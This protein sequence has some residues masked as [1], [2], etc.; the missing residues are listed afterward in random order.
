MIGI[1]IRVSSTKQDTA[2]QEADLKAYANGKESSWY[3]DKA[4]G[5]NMDRPGFQRLLADVRT[6]KIKTIVVW[7]LDRLGRTASGLTALFD[8]LQSLGVNLVSLRD[9]IDLGTSSGRLMA[10]I[11]ASIAAYE[12]EV[13]GERIAAGLAAKRER[14]AKGEDTWNA[15]RPKGTPNKATPEVCQAVREQVAKGIDKATVAKMFSL[16]R[17]TVYAILRAA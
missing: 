16:S 6:R 12:T 2:S 1:Y 15:G 11:I 7:R 8:E 3:Q 17:P 5:K 4:T 10:N 13:R 14:V 9:G